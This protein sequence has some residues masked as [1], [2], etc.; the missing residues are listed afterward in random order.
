MDA[1]IAEAYKLFAQLYMVCMTKLCTL[2]SWQGQPEAATQGLKFDLTP[3]DQRD[4]SQRRSLFDVPTGGK[5]S[6]SISDS[7]LGVIY[8]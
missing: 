5:V 1:F 8:S 2:C 7:I 4:Y 6:N 3:A